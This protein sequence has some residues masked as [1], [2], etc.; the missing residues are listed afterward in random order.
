MKKFLL[1]LLAIVLIAGVLAGVGFT[2]Y[3]LGYMRGAGERP[4]Q[5]SQLPPRD[6]HHFGLDE[7]P[8]HEFG[9]GIGP[10][11]HHDFGPRGFGMGMRGRGFGF[12]APFH[13]LIQ[14][15]ILGLIIWL[16]YKLLTGWRLTLVHPTPPVTRVETI[17]AEPERPSEDG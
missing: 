5:N 16:A 10:S 15:A 11:F 6:D 8:F 3:R 1:T 17:P 9:R 13:F 7:R 12:F 2:G 14:I 4:A